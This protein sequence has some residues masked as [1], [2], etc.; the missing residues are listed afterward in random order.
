MGNI[1]EERRKKD[2]Q[3]LIDNL[4]KQTAKQAREI[5]N[6]NKEIEN[7]KKE[8]SKLKKKMEKIRPK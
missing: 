4:L 6:K 2:P 5:H 3:G 7:L 8:I 1:F